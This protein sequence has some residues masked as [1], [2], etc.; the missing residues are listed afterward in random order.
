MKTL[1][2][3]LLA[4][5]AAAPAL[6][7]TEQALKAFFEGKTV[8]VKLDMP[9]SSAGIDV[10]PDAARADY[11]AY[12]DRIKAYGTSIRAGESSIVT[13]VRVKDKLIEFQL[14]GGGFGTSGDNIGSIPPVHIPITG[15]STRE[16]DLARD[17]KK[18]TD[19]AKKRQME[20][21]LDSLR[22]DREREERL[23]QAAAAAAAEERMTRIAQQR[24]QGGSRFNLR[25]QGGV[26]RGITPG[27]VM[28]ALAE[29][30]DFSGGSRPV[31]ASDAPS[32]P[33]AD[34]V[35]AAST[36]SP[37]TLRKGLTIQEAEALLGKSESATERKEGTLT[38]T[39]AIFLR[40]DERIEAQFVEGVMIKYVISSR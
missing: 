33:M 10:F 3:A 32:G 16:R 37:G 28:A 35:A 34:D 19:P 36:P 31:V 20:E 2:A 18:E 9:A 24:L 5:L 4:T 7:Q 40:G 1:V 13:L 25:Y 23:S 17:I 11:K 21:E 26:P 15:G 27:Q 30:V 29:F 38:V 22:R 8:G 14:G 6:A 39:T 12:G